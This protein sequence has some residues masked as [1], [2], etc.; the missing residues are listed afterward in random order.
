MTLPLS[1]SACGG[2]S[3]NLLCYSSGIIQLVSLRQ[4]FSLACT[5]EL[6]GSESIL[7]LEL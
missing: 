6:P 5:H 7:T 4:S 3:D 1:V 2:Q